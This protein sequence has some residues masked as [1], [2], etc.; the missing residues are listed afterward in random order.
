MSKV[1]IIIRLLL[2]RSCVESLY[3]KHIAQV[4][5]F[6]E[7]ELLRRFVMMYY[8]WGFYFTLNN[9]IGDMIN[10]LV[11]GLCNIPPYVNNYK[12]KFIVFNPLKHFYKPKIFSNKS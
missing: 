6:L 11:L 12:K 3:N 10:S 2:F 4:K 1:E 5:N 9:Y 7:Q 8:E